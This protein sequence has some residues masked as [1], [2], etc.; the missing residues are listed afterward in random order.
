LTLAALAVATQVSAQVTF[1]EHDGFQGRAFTA[2]GAAPNFQQHGFNDR[3]SSAVILGA[4]W[5]VCENTDFGGR[6]MVLREGQYPSLSAMGLNDR[7]SSVRA[8]SR[9]VRIEDDRYAPPAPPAYDNR[10]RGNER[11]Y[12]ADVTS[13]RAVLG[14]PEQRCWV[15]REQVAPEQGNNGVP[16]ALIGAVLGGVLGHQVGGG[17]GRDLAT[18]GG[19]VA[20]AVVGASVG[21]NSGTG[22]AAQTRDVQR[23]ISEPGG[24]RPGY[25]DVTYEFRGQSHRMQMTTAPG[26]TV[27][28]N[29]R[30][31]PRA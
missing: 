3:A 4:P 5:E 22:P 1:Y 18:A 31:E 10:R 28:V 8:V 2:Q 19:A 21:R 16:G 11:L 6:C 30:G 27:T 9:N 25:W 14:T 12:Q 24:A 26:P 17:T 7:V 29:R 20:G 15:E 13:V 23:C